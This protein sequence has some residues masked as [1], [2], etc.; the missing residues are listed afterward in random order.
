MTI[1]IPYENKPKQEVKHTSR[2]IG[3]RICPNCFRTI[4]FQIKL[5]VEA[6]LTTF[7]NRRFFSTEQRLKLLDHTVRVWHTCG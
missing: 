4:S 3:I 6:K 7:T 1:S 2:C 5:N